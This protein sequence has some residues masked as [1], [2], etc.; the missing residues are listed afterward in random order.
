MSNIQGGS[1]DASSV[2][3]TQALDKDLKIDEDNVIDVSLM[4][5]DERNRREKLK[6]EEKA[7]QQK[8]Q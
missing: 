3:W 4:K 5:M 2:D 7:C 6:L 1:T 8:A